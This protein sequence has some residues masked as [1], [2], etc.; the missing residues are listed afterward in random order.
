MSIIFSMMFSSLVKVFFSVAT[1][2]FFEAVTK[3]VLVFVLEKLA[4]MTTNDLDDEIVKEVVLKLNSPS[5]P[6]DKDKN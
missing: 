6:P 4:K 3:K 1:E 2:T 5:I